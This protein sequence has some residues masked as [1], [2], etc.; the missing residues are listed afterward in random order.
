MIFSFDKPKSQA[1]RIARLKAIQYFKKY[2]KSK[3]EEGFYDWLRNNNV[4]I[5]KDY[6]LLN[7]I[8]KIMFIWNIKFITKYINIIIF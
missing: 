7:N 5:I 8:Y 4:N 1:Y 2:H 3:S 6:D